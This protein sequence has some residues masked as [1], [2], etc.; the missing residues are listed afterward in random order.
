LYSSAGMQ[1]VTV[2]MQRNC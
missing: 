2:V 1:L